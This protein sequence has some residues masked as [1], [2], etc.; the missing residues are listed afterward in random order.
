MKLP[1]F[2]DLTQRGDTGW[3]EAQNEGEDRVTFKENSIMSMFCLEA[4]F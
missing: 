2:V 3:K 1:Y 4:W